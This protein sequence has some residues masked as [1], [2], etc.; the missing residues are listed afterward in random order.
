MAA[1]KARTKAETKIK[2]A[3]EDT[4]KLPRKPIPTKATRDYQHPLQLWEEAGKPHIFIDFTGRGTGKTTNLAVDLADYCYKKHRQFIL[5][6]RDAFKQVKRKAWFYNAM[7][8]GLTPYDIRCEGNEFKIGE[9]TI[10]RNY[11]LHAYADYRSLEFPETD[12]VVFEEFVE[13]EPSNYWSDNG[14]SEAQFLSDL[15]STVFRDRSDGC[16]IL[17]GNN[18][19]EDSKYNPYFEAFGIDFDEMDIKIGNFYHIR[20]DK[21]IHICLYYG[22]MGRFSD[23]L[24]DVEGWA[25]F[26]P[27]NDVALTGEFKP[28]PLIL[29]NFLHEHNMDLTDLKPEGTGLAICTQGLIEYVT[30]YSLGDEEYHIVSR[31]AFSKTDYEPYRIKTKLQAERFRMNHENQ[32]LYETAKDAATIRKALD[33]DRIGIQ[34]NQ[35]NLKNYYSLLETDTGCRQEDIRIR[36]F[37]DFDR[38][39]WRN[40]GRCSSRS[41]FEEKIRSELSYD[42]NERWKDICFNRYENLLLTEA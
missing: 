2:E 11:S 14:V 3:A 31:Q 38:W 15:L 28:N 25:A 12:F 40:M 42:I 8:R 5:V 19:N 24:D 17:L 1:T 37:G 20:N 9:Q 29:S 27:E 39:C 21:H 16:C 6:S 30:F 22:G 35:K 4:E 13:L 36:T 18:L 41:D 32:L 23:D 7:A 10:G 34:E 26:L 33:P